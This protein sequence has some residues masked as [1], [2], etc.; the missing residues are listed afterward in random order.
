MTTP[1]PSPAE[2]AAAKLI[3]GGLTETDAA[4]RI[5]TVLIKHGFNATVLPNSSHGDAATSLFMEL[6]PEDRWLFGDLLARA[7][8]HNTTRPS[9]NISWPKWVNRAFESAEATDQVS[10]ARATLAE[11]LAE[12]EHAIRR[13]MKIRD[14]LAGP[15]YDIEHAEGNQLFNH[16]LT[17]ADR[18]IRTAAQINPTRD[19]K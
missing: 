8:G 17:E 9:G 1:T 14:N 18:A 2:A 3:E 11:A 10:E 5:A 6:A 16:Y 15:L 4:N 12:A 13:V 19:L 7:S